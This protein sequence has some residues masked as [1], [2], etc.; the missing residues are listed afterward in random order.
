MGD[1]VQPSVVGRQPLVQ[2]ALRPLTRCPPDF[3]L[4]FSSSGWHFRFPSPLWM[5]HCIPCS[6]DVTAHEAPPSSALGL[7]TGR[8]TLET[9]IALLEVLFVCIAAGQWELPWAEW[10]AGREGHVFFFCPVRRSSQWCSL[11]T[12]PFLTCTLF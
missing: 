12:A 9:V 3:F 2:L 8:A 10:E 7:A 5:W 4:Q 6:P 11:R 1:T